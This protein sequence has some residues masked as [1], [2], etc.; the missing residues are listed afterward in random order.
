MNNN[1]IWK[2]KLRHLGL[3]I[4]FTIYSIDEERLYVQ[5]G[6]LKT[7]INELLLYRILDIKSSR[8]LIQKLFGVGTITL[9]CADQSS[10]TLELRNIKN[11]TETHKLISE[12]VES[13]REQKGMTGR[14][15]FGAAG[16]LD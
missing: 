14:E 3:P 11:C 5:S 7:E 1:L 4:S 6:L 12:L 2:D 13:I 15:I 16:T 10:N 8:T 9:F